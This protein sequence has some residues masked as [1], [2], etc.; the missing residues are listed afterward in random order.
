MASWKIVYK[1]TERTIENVSVSSARK[2]FAVD[3]SGS[4]GGAPLFSEEAFVNAFHAASRDKTGDA[5]TKWGSHCQSPTYKWDQFVWR[6]D[7]GGT[8]PS[9]IL[10]NE[11]ALGA[12]HSSDIFFLLTDGEVWENEVYNLARLSQEK[13]IFNCPTV[14]LITSWK[15]GTPDE[16]NVSVGITAYANCASAICLFK[17]YQSEGGIYI[18]AAKGVFAGLDKATARDSWESLTKFRDEKELIAAMDTLK[19][20]VPTASTRPAG[21]PGLDLGPKWNA[22]H[23]EHTLVDLTKLL[24]TGAVSEE[25]AALLFDEEAIDALILACKSW[26]KLPKLRRF[27]QAQRVDQ[28]SVQLEDVS[29]AADIIAKLGDTGLTAQEKASL[30]TQ[31]RA[32]HA[33]NRDHY[34]TAVNSDSRGKEA[35]ARNRL[36]DGAMSSLAE[37][38][39]IGFT[40]DVLS[41]RSN[42]AK[43]AADVTSD[44]AVEVSILD[45]EAPAY[46][47][48]CEICCGEEEI[49]SV[50]LKV[51]T[52]DEA[53]AN[54]ADFALDFPLAAGRFAAN[55]N[56]VSSQCI[57]FQCA[58][59][60]RPGRS[61]FGEEIAVVLPT[62]QYAGSNKLYINQQLY[63]AL[64]GGLKTGVP[65]LGQLFATIL[66]RT[67][68]EKVWAGAPDPSSPKAPDQE[69]QK[70]RN[71][72]Q[73]LLRSV[74]DNL[75]VRET[76]KELGEWTTYPKALAWAAKDFETE[77]LTS[78]AVNYPVS[79]FMQLI[80]FGTLTK[81][82]SPERVRDMKATKL[83][84][85]F[86]STY[87][88]KL[89]QQGKNRQWTKDL[90]A[91]VY[92]QFNS[93][94]VPRD[95]GPENTVLSDVEEFWTALTNFLGAE[96]LLLADWEPTDQA[97]FMPRIQVLTF[98][99]VY[100]QLAHTSAKTYFTK[101]K[102]SEPL[103]TTVLNLKATL[104]K[105][106][107]DEVRTD[108]GVLSNIV[109]VLLSPF[110]DK[111]SFTSRR[112]AVSH[113][114]EVIPFKSPFGASVLRCGIES[115]RVSFVP[116]D[117][118]SDLKSVE[119]TPQLVDAVRSAR[120][121]HLIDVFSTDKSFENSQTGLPEPTTMPRKPTSSHTTLH[122]GIART[123]ARQPVDERRAIAQAVHDGQID[124]EALAR[125]VVAVKNEICGNHRGDIFS[126]TL[127][128]DAVRLMPGFMTT[129]RMALVLEGKD[130]G[131]VALYEHDFAQNKME[132]KIK[133]EVAVDML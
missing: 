60:G 43:R 11:T 121:Q 45:L 66:D 13:N 24:E 130:A 91:M 16:A 15:R 4:T 71:T 86:V 77:G 31:L 2:F 126:A 98:W 95:I 118:G 113:D 102:E 112:I 72:L 56:I 128:G 30:Q 108:C 99:L 52:Q 88:A 93:E 103:S 69:V 65:I 23:T 41:R 61:I 129:L 63:V 12:I 127:A 78:W 5:L 105:K 101:L 104:P 35:R 27:L 9:D 7:M 90:L 28:V 37:V 114:V 48:E 92:S 58:L 49:M 131:D 100:F 110:V 18:I 17:N 55:V 3:A 70:R 109:Q 74:V 80:R 8:C 94:L 62:L 96:P 36:V 59:F 34:L 53:L 38:E 123:W 73:W 84:H 46:R 87:L 75:R 111:S 76:F 81:A 25:D 82:F 39:K 44:A 67:L 14:F 125:F 107:S 50:A 57:C 19:I 106:V 117:I 120:R 68:Q 119:W 64:N 124:A 97:N 22:A 51:L 89:F 47:A 29:G 20:E 26:G 85:S 116:Q 54:T 132:A 42:R 6:S 32:A 79:G 115:C 21:L 33:A 10:V 122:I 1:P 133:Y 40:A 83:L